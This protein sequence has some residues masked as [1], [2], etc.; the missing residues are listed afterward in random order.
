LS[1]KK[2]LISLR[3]PK[4]HSWIPF[5]Y[6]DY[7]NDPRANTTISPISGGGE[8]STI[9]FEGNHSIFVVRFTGFASWSGRFSFTPVDM[10]PRSFSGIAMFVRCKSMA[11]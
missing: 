7:S 5:I 3:L 4:V 1:I 11:N 6:C 10:L 9:Y 8:N 2:K